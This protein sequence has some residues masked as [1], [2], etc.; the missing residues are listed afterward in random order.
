MFWLVK[1]LCDMLVC[2]VGCAFL[3]VNF[4]NHGFHR[5][6]SGRWWKC[7]G[8]IFVVNC[9]VNMWNWRSDFVGGLIVIVIKVGNWFSLIFVIVMERCKSYFGQIR[10]GRSIFWYI[11]CAKKM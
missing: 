2:E 8:Y 1:F 5:F 7:Y 10:I 9:A 3:V 6:H 4:Y 11:C